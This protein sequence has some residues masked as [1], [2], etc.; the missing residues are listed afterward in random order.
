MGTK[1]AGHYELL[2]RIGSGGA[3]VLWR[4]RDEKLDRIVALKFLSP[5]LVNNADAR[6][7]FAMEARAASSID[8]PNICTIYEIGD[9]PEGEIYISMAYYGGTTLKSVLEQGPITPRRAVPIAV[10]IA[11]GLSAAHEELIIHRDIKPGNVM[12][13]DHD[14]VKIVDFGLAKC[15]NRVRITDPNLSL[16]TPAYMSPEQIRGEE[17]DVRTDIWSLGVVLFEMV[18]GALP[19]KGD[20][21]GAVINSILNGEPRSIKDFDSSLPNR[22]SLVIAKA[23]Q[24]SPR[25]RYQCADEMIAE[26]RDLLADVDSDAQTVRRSA[27]G[28]RQSSVA[29]LPFTDMSAERDQEYLCDGLAEEILGAIRRIPELRVASRT[30]SFQFK[31][32]AADIR[33]IGHKLNVETVLEGSVRRA[34]D[35]LRVSAQLVS[36]ADGYRLWYERYDRDLKDVF[37]IQDEIANCIAEAL[38]V[39]LGGDATATSEIVPESAEAWELYLQGRQFFLQHRRKSF[40]VARQAFMEAIRVDPGYARAWAGIANCHSFTRLYFGGGTEETTEAEVA[41]L[42]AIELAPQLAEARLARGLALFLS[43]KMDEA[44]SELVRAIEIDPLLYEA[45]YFWGRIAFTKGD[46]PEAARHFERACSISPE[47]FDSWYLMGMAC[48]KLGEDARARKADLDCIE[49][50]KKQIRV[51]ADDTRAWTMGAAVFAEMGEPERA[52]TWVSRAVAI[53]PDEPSVNYNAACVYVRLDRPDEAI[54]CLSSSVTAGALQKDWILNDP[55]LDP[56]RQDPRFVALVDGLESI[57][58]N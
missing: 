39:T 56:L 23:L 10:Q 25:A 21:A 27:T 11:R 49:A 26:L 20:T 4:A 6:A 17:V 28:R 12:M 42:R 18:T 5:E 2:E 53:G 7:R 38:E 58:G 41:S 13:A 48:R 29:V 22:L 37:A 3:G 34:G 15:T 50:V 54:A 51:H 36:V 55:D 35:R 31:G 9:T 43:G 40:E 52:L 16:G 44:E 14:T 8:H 30:S 33:E 1:A 47:A 45:H 32:R 57:S 19:F 24:K 46:M